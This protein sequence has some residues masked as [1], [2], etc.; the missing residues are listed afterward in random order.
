MLIKMEDARESVY[1]DWTI[2]DKVV[3]FEI[4]KLLDGIEPEEDLDDDSRINQIVNHNYNYNYNGANFMNIEKF[5]AQKGSNQ[6]IAEKVENATIGETKKENIFLNFCKSIKGIIALT[7]LLIS[8][9]VGIYTI[10]DS[11]SFKNDVMMKEKIGQSK[12]I[13]N[14]FETSDSLKIDMEN[15]SK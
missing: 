10:R 15:K 11:R 1:K 9:L 14:T 2:S 13:E 8:I 3:E 6:I 12:A 5:E 4:S 7:A